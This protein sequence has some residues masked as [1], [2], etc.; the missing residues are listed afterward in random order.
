MGCFEPAHF[1]NPHP[2]TVACMENMG[3]WRSWSNQTLKPMKIAVIGAGWAGGAAAYELSKHHHV[4]LFEASR[5]VGGRARQVRNTPFGYPTDNGQHILLGA[6]D[7]TL[8]IMSE[9]GLDLHDAFHHLELSI[10]NAERTFEIQVWPLPAP[11][12]LLGA[13]LSGRGF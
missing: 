2:Q 8:K 7:H 10:L 5:Q 12:H 3:Q 6:Y 11:L 4:T 9:L 13:I 1:L